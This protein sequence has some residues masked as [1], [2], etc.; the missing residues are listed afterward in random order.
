MFVTILFSMALALVFCCLSFIYIDKWIFFNNAKV[1]PVVIKVKIVKKFHLK[2]RTKLRFLYKYGS[3]IPKIVTYPE[4]CTIY[5]KYESKKYK[6]DTYRSLFDTLR[7]GDMHE[8]KA[9]KFTGAGFDRKPR[10][11]YGDFTTN[12]TFK[13]KR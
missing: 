10:V 11:I 7:V 2:E 1:E 8:L 4:V 12:F 9:C 6:T 5:F 3:Y 13:E